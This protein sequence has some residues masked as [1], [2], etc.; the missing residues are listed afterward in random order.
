MLLVRCCARIPSIRIRRVARRLSCQR[1]VLTGIGC[2]RDGIEWHFM[3]SNKINMYVMDSAIHTLAKHTGTKHN[4][5]KHN[6]TMAQWHNGTMAQWHNGT[7]AQWHNGTMAQWHN[8]TMAQWHNGTM[9]QWHNGTMAQWHNGTMAQ[10]HNG[11]MA[12]WH[13]GT[14][15]QWHNGTMAQW[16]NGTMAQWHNGTMAQWHNGT[17]AQWH[18]GTMAQWHN[19]TMAQWHNG[20]MAQWHNGTMAQWHNDTMTQ[21]TRRPLRGRNSFEVGLDTVCYWVLP[22]KKAKKNVRTVSSVEYRK[23]D[24]CKTDRRSRCEKRTHQRAVRIHGND[25]CVICLEN[26]HDIVSGVY[27]PPVVTACDHVFHAACWARYT[28]SVAPPLTPVRS[29]RFLQ[30]FLLREVGPPCPTCRMRRPM[31]HTFALN[32]MSSEYQASICVGGISP[33]HALALANIN[34]T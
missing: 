8:G 18:N 14:M 2:V 32:L 21:S 3:N 10:W 30:S 17:M 31:L 6:G 4:G 15:A 12:Q 5:T 23:H 22:V 13:N 9:A 19:G 11:T 34:T 33:N 25:K 7:M 27:S 29:I 28:D 26:V 20:T 1:Q 16:H 24:M